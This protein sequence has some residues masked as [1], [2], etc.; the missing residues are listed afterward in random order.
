MSAILIKRFCEQGPRPHDTC[1][2][3]ELGDAADTVI[4]L[5]CIRQQDAGLSL[6]LE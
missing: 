4:P 1:E 6:G 5:H 2:H 3:P